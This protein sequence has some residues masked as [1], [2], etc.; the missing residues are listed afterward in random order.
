MKVFIYHYIVKPFQTLFKEIT[1][2]SLFFTSYVKKKI[3]RASM[4]F[5]K[6]KNLLI[7]FFLMKRGRYTRPFLH[8]T[9]MIV[10][11]IGIF[12]SPYLADTYPLLSGG[13]TSS[14]SA[15]AAPIQESIEVSDSVFQTDRSSNLRSKVVT[16]TVQNGDTIHSIANKFSDPNN[17]ITVDT[18]KWANN[19]TTDDVSVGDQLQIPPVT[20]I[21]HKVESGETVYTL[22]K[23]YNTEAQKIVDFP[24]NDFANPETFSLIV[25]Q[26][27]IIPDGV[28]PEEVKTYKKTQEVGYTELAQ[29][30]VPVVTSGFSFPLP[31]NTGISQYASWYHMA[32]DITAPVGTPVYAAH[33]GTVTRVSIGTWDTGYGT[34]VWI[35]NGSG[36]ESHYAHLSSISVSVG[37]SVSAGQTIL[38]MSGN[39]GKSTGPHTHFEI[40]Q[41][42]ILVNPLSYV[43]N[44]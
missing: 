24:F 33:S 28:K 6:Q 12:I 43:G 22:A 16:Y 21:V 4:S 1:L 2:F 27:L 38:G 18:I 31:S 3:H 19:L 29:G 14:L 34:N 40:R 44:R 39:T 9:T 7:K 37:Q 35:S 20:G 32:L 30:V 23:K 25:G 11:G 41:N 17:Q 13:N 36:I 5:E 10:L 8:I 26:Q 42:G 15:N